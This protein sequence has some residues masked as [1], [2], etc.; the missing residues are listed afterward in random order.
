MEP[1][2]ARALLLNSSYEP[3]LVLTWQKALILWF[4]EKVEVLEFHSVFARSVSRSF[5]IPS[6]LRL[7]TYV[8]PKIYGRVRFCRDNIYLRDNYTC[9]YC[10]VRLPTKQLTLDHVVPASKRGP[11]TWQN[12]V[13][14]CR[15]CNQR[16]A[17]RTPELAHMPLIRKPHVPSWLPTHEIGVGGAAPESWS[18]YLRPELQRRVEGLRT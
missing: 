10:A 2:S 11:N 7:K 14:A 16:K 9:Q 18:S 13:T 12:V 6:V 8:R 3:M 1:A 5:Q 4:Q 17:D 15:A